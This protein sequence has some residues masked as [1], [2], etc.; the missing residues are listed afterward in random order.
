MTRAFRFGFPNSRTFITPSGRGRTSAVLWE[1]AVSLGFPQSASQIHLRER[2]IDATDGA[3]SA[4]KGSEVSGVGIPCRTDRCPILSMR[5]STQPKA[6]RVQRGDGLGPSERGRRGGT[7]EDRSSLGRVECS[8]LP[9]RRRM[10]I[11]SSSSTG[12]AERFC[13]FERGGTQG[14][15][16]GKGLNLQA[17]IQ[18]L[19][20]IVFFNLLGVL[21]LRG[22]PFR[23]DT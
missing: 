15:G 13:L 11:P 17:E 7:G 9:Y 19:R 4:R 3:C 23:R 22:P 21:K 10:G 14:P 12:A 5:N 2:L 16:P 20:R 6:N 8:R 1:G 18:R